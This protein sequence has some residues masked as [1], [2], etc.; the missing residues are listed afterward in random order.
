MKLGRIPVLDAR[1]RLFSVS[2]FFPIGTP[3]VSKEWDCQLWLDQGQVSACVGYSWC[4]YLASEPDPISGVTPNLALKVYRMAQLL[5]DLPGEAYE[6]TSI[7][8]GIKAIKAISP[9]AIE[10]YHWAFGIDELI[11]TLG[12]LGPVVLG[13]NWY[14][15]M[16]APERDTGIINVS[17]A[18]VGGHAILA[19]GVDVFTRLVRLHNSWGHGYG[20]NGDCYI[21]FENLARLLAEQGECCVPTGKHTKIIEI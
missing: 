15:S 11:L 21:S 13:I 2:Q 10:S 6:G 18:N 19:V 5:D 4:H 7:L 9:D 16:F 14:S 3:P 1:S 20:I 8:A 17:G 12:Y